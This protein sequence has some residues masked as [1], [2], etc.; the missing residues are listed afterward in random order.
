MT[1]ALRERLVLMLILFSTGFIQIGLVAMNVRQIATHHYFGAFLCSTAIGI[2]WSINVK[3][4]AFGDWWDRMAYAVGCGTGC[5]V[6]LYITT[7]IYG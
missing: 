5:V 4:V 7:I 6:G 2:I 3:R 1:L